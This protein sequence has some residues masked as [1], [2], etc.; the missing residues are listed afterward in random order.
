MKKKLSLIFLL[1]VSIGFAQPPAG[2]YNSATGTGYTLKTQLHD[3]ITANYID[4]TYSGLYITYTTSDKDFYYENDGT[5]LDVYT[6]NPTGPE[7]EFTYGTGQDD[8]SLGNN[9]CERR[10][11]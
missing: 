10:Y 2:Y 3:I 7:C 9:E 4:K 6:E 11:Y 5:M 8:G 1:L